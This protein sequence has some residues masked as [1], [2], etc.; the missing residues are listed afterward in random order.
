[1]L[2]LQIYYATGTPGLTWN[3]LTSTVLGVSYNN[4]CVVYILADA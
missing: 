1:M 4:K 3:Q 2:S